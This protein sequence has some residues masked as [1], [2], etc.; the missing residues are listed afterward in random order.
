MATDCIF[1]KIAKGEIPVTKVFEDDYCL[2]F[3]DI[4][5][6]A[7]THL[8]LVPKHHLMSHAHATVEHRQILGHL[9]EVAA[10]IARMEELSKGYRIVINTGPDGGQSVDH[11]HLHILGGRPMTWPPG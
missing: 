3:P 1:C 5:P 9:L 2:C 7:P 4:D 10:E 8:L 11:L 6:Q